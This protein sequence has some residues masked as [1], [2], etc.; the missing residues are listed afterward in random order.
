MQRGTANVVRVAG[1][2]GPAVLDPYRR[3]AAQAEPLRGALPCPASITVIW[4]RRAVDM[5]TVQNEI[6]ALSALSG[7]TCSDVYLAPNGGETV[8]HNCEM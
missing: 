6:A 7:T 4:G 2:A 8:H 3:A 5:S 1:G